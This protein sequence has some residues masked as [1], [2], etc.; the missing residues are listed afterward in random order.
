MSRS[1]PRGLLISGALFAAAL[2]GGWSVQAQAPAKQSWEGYPPTN[3]LPNPYTTVEGY[4]KLGRPSGSTSAVDIDRDGK[5]IWFAER[6]GSNTCA[7]TPDIDPIYHFAADGSLIKSFGKGLIIFPHGIY[8]DKDDNIWVTDGQDNAPPAGRGGGGAAPVGPNPAATK[9]HQIWKFSPNGDVLMT[10]G[11]AGGAT[12]PTECCWQPNDVITN[13]A[14]EIFVTEGHGQ[15]PNDRI[16]K[17]DKNGKFLQA[18]GK[19]GT[20]ELE[21]NQP[22]ALAF[23]SQGR[24]FVG[25]RANNRIVVFDK[26]MKQV[27][28]WP[29][30]SRPSGI[31]IDKNDILYSADSESGGVNPA[32]GQW[33]R[34]IRIGS[35]KDGKVTAFIPDPLPLCPQGQR[36][37]DPPTCASGTWVAEGVAVDDAGNVYG[38]EVGPRKMQKYVKK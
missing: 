13:A 3:N 35:A 22:H 14:G 19:R 28:D 10:I 36:P 32:H 34:G 33:T 30:F 24:L 1:I 27:A 37:G 25:D 29:Q 17:F 6:C 11:K 2:A 21:F 38:A 26:N 8:V 31:F 23:D 7:N 9:G 15:N 18:W 16:V 4:F 20:G 5:T 12:G